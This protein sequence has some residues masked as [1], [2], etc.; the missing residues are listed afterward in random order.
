MVLLSQCSITVQDWTAVKLLRFAFA[1][2]WTT[3]GTHGQ[4]CPMPDAYLRRNCAG[5]PNAPDAAIGLLAANVAMYRGQMTPMRGSRVDHRHVPTSVERLVWPLQDYRIAERYG[6]HQGEA[7]QNGRERI[8][9]E[10][11]F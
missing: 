10:K 8:I 7:V 1:V 2:A 11:F 3:A 9:C 5:D 6:P 4:F